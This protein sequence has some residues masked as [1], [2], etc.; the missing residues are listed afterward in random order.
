[1]N[2][3]QCWIEGALVAKER[4]RMGY[5]RV[6]TPIKTQ[7]YERMIKILSSVEMK[8]TKRITIDYPVRATLKYY[9]LVPKSKPEKYRIAAL[10]GR[11]CPVMR[12]DV[13]NLVKATLDGIQGA[14]ITNDRLVVGLSVS[15]YYAE[16]EGVYI[17]INEYRNKY[18][19]WS[20]TNPIFLEIY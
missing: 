12:K 14:V 17:A 11:F 13:D 4:P 3:F 19:H 16:V 7:N 10:S 15:C 1:M 5:N 8:K 18:E 20:K 9:F 2:Y 6:Y